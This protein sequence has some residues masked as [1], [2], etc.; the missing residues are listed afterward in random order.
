MGC[1]ISLAFRFD[2][3]HSVADHPD[4]GHSDDHLENSVV[5]G[6]TT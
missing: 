5:A 4:I 6:Q 3:H 2:R 1:L